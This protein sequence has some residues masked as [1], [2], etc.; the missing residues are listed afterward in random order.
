MIKRNRDQHTNI[1]EE[2]RR[3]NRQKDKQRGT[4]QQNE[5]FLF[6]DI[7]STEE[8]TLFLGSLYQDKFFFCLTNSVRDESES[9]VKEWPF[10]AA[11][12]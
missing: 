11:I 3:E 12:M 2:T 7:F 4:V 1:E 8:F 9:L 5:R 10:I 6:S